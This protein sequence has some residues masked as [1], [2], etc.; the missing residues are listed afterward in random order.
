MYRQLRP[1][2][3]PW[4]NAHVPPVP[5]AGQHRLQGWL[6]ADFRRRSRQGLHWQDLAP[7]YQLALQAWRD[8]WPQAGDGWADALAAQWEVAGGDSRLGWEQ[9]WEVVQDTWRALASLPA[10]G[11]TRQ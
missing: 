4:L 3:V 10:D 11:C 8:C 7:A 6:M 2:S 9:A 5:P 1:V